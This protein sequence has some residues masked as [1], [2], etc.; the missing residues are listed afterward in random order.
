ML[1]QECSQVPGPRGYVAFTM[2]KLALTWN[3]STIFKAASSATPPSLTNT[4]R[5]QVPC[6]TIVA[7]MRPVCRQFKQFLC[8]AVGV[9]LNKCSC[10]PHAIPTAVRCIAHIFIR[11]GFCM[12]SRITGDPRLRANEASRMEVFTACVRLHMSNFSTLGACMDKSFWAWLGTS[13]L[14]VVVEAD[15]LLVCS[16]PEPASIPRLPGRR[17]Q[18]AT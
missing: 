8:D 18:R 4:E 2:W 14:A 17:C 11:N 10:D 12:V 13:F 16:G 6:R 5:G 1:P 3:A 7:L 9:I 15:R